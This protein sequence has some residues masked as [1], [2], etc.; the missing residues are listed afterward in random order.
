MTES[1]PVSGMWARPLK[2][3]GVQAAGERPDPLRPWRCSPVQ[4]I[5]K[6]SPPMPFEVGSTTV[7]A[8]AAARA[9][10]TALPPSWSISR[11]ACAARGWLVAT[12][13]R[14]KTGTRREA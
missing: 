8:M 1:Q 13:F 6:A 14:A 10:S 2:R 9:A 4:T 5:A 3:S 12:T 7:S 11:P